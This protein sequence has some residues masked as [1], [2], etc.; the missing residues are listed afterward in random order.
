MTRSF[1]AWV[2]STA[3][4]L[5]ADAAEVLAFVD[6]APAEFWDRDSVVA[7]WLNRDVL[8]HMAGGNDQMVQVVLR[9][10]L[11][12]QPI[13]AGVLEPDTDADNAA[14][15]AER[16]TWPLA[17]VIAEFDQGAEEMLDLLSRL[18]D[19]HAGVRLGDGTF[20]LGKLLRIVERER[21]DHLHLEQLRAGMSTHL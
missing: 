12:G 15:I 4:M 21:H 6:S 1:A 11:A 14:G 5:G 20:T 13:D 9:A 7:G 10:V 8:A 2:H 18:S 17:D 19:A 16:R 3:A